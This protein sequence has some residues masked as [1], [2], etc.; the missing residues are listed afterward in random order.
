MATTKKA[1][2][3]TTTSARPAAA[4][5]V[6]NAPLFGKENYKWMLIG[7]VLI[8]LGLFLMGGGKSK[9]PNVF[10]PKEVYS[11]TRITLA[12]ILILGGFVIEIFAIF[13]KDKEKK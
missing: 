6:Q 10:N 1:T 3:A 7:I 13:R 8:A 5:S 2:S 4:S 11:F 9:D 12:P